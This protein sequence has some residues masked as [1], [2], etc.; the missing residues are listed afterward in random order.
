MKTIPACWRRDRPPRLSDF[1]AIGSAP[2]RKGELTHV[3]TWAGRGGFGTKMLQEHGIVGIIY[4]GTFLDDD[5]RDRTVADKWFAGQIQQRLA[6]KDMEA[7]TKYRYDPKFNTG[8]TFGVNYAGMEGSILAFNY[9][10]IYWTEDGAARIFTSVS[11]S[12]TT[13]NN[14]TRRPSKPS[15][16]IP[17]GNP[18]R[19]CARRCSGEFK[20]DYE[21]Y[22]TMGPLCGIFD[23]RAAER[24]NHHADMLGFDAISVGG[25]LCWLMD[26]LDRGPAA[27]GGTGRDGSAGVLLEGFDVVATRCTMPSW[28][29]RC[30]TRSRQ[31]AG[32]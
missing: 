31:K 5:F 13:S 27:T 15:N 11:S 7:T 29:W 19:R 12:I 2:V 21:P 28:A 23:Q 10:T 6:A 24:L 14:S 26:C 8:G 17:A 20:K 30:S 32:S 16:S 1:G 4:G 18:A 9:R 3:D 25:V 22:Q